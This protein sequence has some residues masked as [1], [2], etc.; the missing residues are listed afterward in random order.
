VVKDLVY[1]FEKEGCK[2]ITLDGVRVELEKGWFI[3]R[4]SN[5]LPQVRLIAEA[6]SKQALEEIVSYAET[7]LMETLSKY[8]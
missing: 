1:M 5:T 6:R 2:T 3:L 4:P 7:R 8:N